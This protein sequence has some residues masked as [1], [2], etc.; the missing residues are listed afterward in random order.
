[1]RMP[2]AF[3]DLQE[4]VLRQDFTDG[5]KKVFILPNH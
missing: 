3:V 5:V 2:D 1:M 4:D